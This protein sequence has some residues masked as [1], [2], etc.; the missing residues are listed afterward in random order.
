[1]FV[2]YPKS[3]QVTGQF[4]WNAV[5]EPVKIANKLIAGQLLKRK[6]A[7]FGVVGS[8]LSG[9]AVHIIQSDPHIRMLL[10]PFVRLDPDD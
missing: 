4:G 5:P 1:M 3:L 2:G 9:A 8:D 6:D 7:P 10:D